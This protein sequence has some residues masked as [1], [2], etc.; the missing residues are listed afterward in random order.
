[1]EWL[2]TWGGKCFGYRGGD[3]LFTHSGVQAGQFDGAE[4]YGADGL[5]LDELMQ[6]RLIRDRNK[7]RQ[8]KSASTPAR[9][10]S[11]VKYVD[12]VG[13]VMYVGHEDFPAPDTFDE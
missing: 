6:D 2:W 12:Y 7:K 5:Y 8:R 1:M 13:Y 9:V 11:Y 4:V 3:R 10:D